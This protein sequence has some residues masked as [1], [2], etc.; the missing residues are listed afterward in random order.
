LLFPDSA[1]RFCKQRRYCLR[2]HDTEKTKPLR[3]ED[4]STAFFSA[5]R[6]FS[7]TISLLGRR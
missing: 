6:A 3:R 4:A 2:Q 1:A 7:M 5:V